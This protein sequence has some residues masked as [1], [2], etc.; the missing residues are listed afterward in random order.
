[1]KRIFDK[2]KSRLLNGI[3]KVMN[4]QNSKCRLHYIDIGMNTIVTYK[5]KFA[6]D[7]GG[8]WES[9]KALI[10]QPLRYVIKPVPHTT[11][12]YTISTTPI[13]QMA[14]RRLR[15]KKERFE[16]NKQQ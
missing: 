4:R 11:Y 10:W 9:R 3:D 1:M 16:N 12:T 6:V 7:C 8:L 15:R 14:V 13:S 5:N 2:R